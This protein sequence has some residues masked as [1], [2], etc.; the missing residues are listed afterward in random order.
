MNIHVLK[1]WPNSNLS[2]AQA[3][4]LNVPVI[5]RDIAGNRSIV[6]HGKTGLL[7][8]S[9]QVSFVENVFRNILLAMNVNFTTVR[10]TGSQ[11]CKRR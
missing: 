7:Y 6:Q 5:A 9:P 2:F 10:N 8:S 3:M 4:A 1:N 11:Q